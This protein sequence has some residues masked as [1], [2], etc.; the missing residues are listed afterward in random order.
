MKMAARERAAGEGVG[1]HFSR[2][3]IT[4]SPQSPQTFVGLDEIVSAQVRD[5]WWRQIRLGNR[6]PAEPGVILIRGGKP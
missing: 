4:T 6:L 1:I 5:I 2:D 3:S